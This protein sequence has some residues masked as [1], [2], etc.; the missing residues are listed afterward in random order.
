METNDMNKLLMYFT[1][2]LSAVNDMVLE[3]TNSNISSKKD[4]L[5]IISKHLTGAL[6]T[7]AIN[8]ICNKHIK[9]NKEIKN[10]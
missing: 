4:V 7:D 9:A 8:E 3:I 10:E 1:N 2:Y 5:E 6:D